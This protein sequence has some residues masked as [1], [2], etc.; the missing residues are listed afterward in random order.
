MDE[1]QPGVHLDREPEVR[2]GDERLPGDAERLLDEA[3]LLLAAPDVLDHRVREDD[4][5]L[6][7]LERQRE[8]VALDV[9][10]L[11]VP[12]PKPRSL[13][14]AEGRDPLRATGSAPRSS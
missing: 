11:R 13:V 4:V 2:R 1:R 5:E 8:R 12:L 14:Q 7:V 3:P 9:A 10:H 6:S